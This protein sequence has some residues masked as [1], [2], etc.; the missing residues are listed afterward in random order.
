VLQDALTLHGSQFKDAAVIVASPPC[1]KYSY[2]AMPWS[3][4]KAL[5]KHYEASPE[6]RAELTAL[7]DACF[8]IQ[9]EASEAA[10]RRIPLIVEN[11]RG[12]Q[13]WVGRAKANYG[14]YYLWG[15]V[16]MVG[17]RV[18]AGPELRYGHVACRRCAVARSPVGSWDLTR[19]NYNADHSWEPGAVGVKLGG[20]KSW[21][22]FGKPGYIR[23]DSTM[24][25]RSAS[26]QR[27]WATSTSGTDTHTRA[28]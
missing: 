19:K 10:G 13:R 12:A 22:D 27:P 23:S 14:S 17:R 15:D 8:R 18:V 9:R 4:A 20:G 5:I 26:A 25:T 6:N 24:R 7:F 28:T 3:K 1:Q 21:S 2:M 11:V 16:G